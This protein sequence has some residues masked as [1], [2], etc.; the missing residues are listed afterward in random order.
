LFSLYQHSQRLLLVF[1]RPEAIELYYGTLVHYSFPDYIGMECPSEGTFV[2]AVQTD[3]TD[4]ESQQQQ[5]QQHQQQ[6][7]T[8]G[9]IGGDSGRETHTIALARFRDPSRGVPGQA[10]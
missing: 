9:V 5:Q 6:K 2:V 10:A 1:A 7:Q 3:E 4:F 8:A